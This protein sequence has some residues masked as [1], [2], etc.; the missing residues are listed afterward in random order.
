MNERE[1]LAAALLKEREN[2]DTAVDD[3]RAA[4]KRTDRLIED[5]QRFERLR[6]RTEP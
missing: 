6:R 3:L 5:Y 4:L 1:K 2:H